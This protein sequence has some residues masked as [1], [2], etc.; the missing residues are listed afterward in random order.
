MRIRSSTGAWLTTR[1]ILLKKSVFFPP[2][3]HQLSTALWLKWELM[4]LLPESVGWT[5]LVQAAIELPLELTTGLV[6]L[7][8]PGGIDILRSYLTSS[9]YN[10]SN[11]PFTMVPELWWRDAIQY[12]IYGQTVH[13]D[14][15]SVPW[16]VVSF[17]INHYM[18][19]KETSLIKSEGC[20]NMWAKRYKL[21][22]SLILCLFSKIRVIGSPLRSV[23]APILG[24]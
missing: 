10:I 1:A 3:N 17:C 23:S 12:P 7:S 18:L 19:Q 15:F 24:F 16:Q 8:C 6:I 9:S 13:W 20:T 14:L 5:N 22:D 11:S 21:K 2:R 4:D